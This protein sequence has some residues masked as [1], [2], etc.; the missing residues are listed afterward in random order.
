MTNNTDLKSS[1]KVLM[2]L[3]VMID[4]DF[5]ALIYYIKNQSKHISDKD[6]NTSSNDET[7]DST[8]IDALRFSI[9]LKSCSFIDEWDRF[10][11]IRNENEVIS[12]VKLI[13]GV[14]SKVRRELNHWKDLRNFRNE[15]IAHNFRDRNN[16][17]T[18][19]MMGDYNCPQTIPEL[20]Y[21]TSLIERMIRVVTANYSDTTNEIIEKF[22]D[23]TTKQKRSNFDTNFKEIESKLQKIDKEISNKIFNIYNCDLY[24]ELVKNI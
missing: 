14:V 7:I 11:G 22:G 3:Y 18:I 6:G 5:E 1:I 8:I 23:T 9:I 2:I 16:I 4:Q 17:V 19:D 10:L 20:Y 21:L 15:I 13:K 24:S 12:R